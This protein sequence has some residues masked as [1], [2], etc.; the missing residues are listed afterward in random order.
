M[1]PPRASLVVPAHN[2]AAVIGRLL[3]GVLAGA[4]PGEFS[5]VVVANGCADDT[6]RIAR[7]FGPDVQVIET[8]MPSKAAALRLGDEA[9][10]GFPRLYVDA[11]VELGADDVRALAAVL[12]R[13]G[14]L[15]A[16]PH[17]VLD[18]RRASLLVR[19]YYDVWNRLPAVAGG[20]FG[21]GV[22][23]VTEE[24]NRRLRVLPEVMA[25]DL[26]ASMAFADGERVV[27]SGARVIVHPPRTIADLLR[28]R[29]R[30]ATSVTQV[31]R[32]PDMAEPPRTG[33]RDLA[34][35]ARREPAL[36]HKIAWFALVAV[37]A[38]SRARRAVRRGDFATWLR[39]ESSRQGDHR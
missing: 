17:R 13:P 24:G 31:D 28:R 20:L 36:L 27:T 29:V 34:G 9:A 18:L 39:D 22:I 33:M 10:A 15:A 25:D 2:E 1:S 23:G 8:P 35:L 21:R 14:V 30:A 11:D 12:E 4:A 38:K 16:G 6:A 3:D 26:A 32:R 5:V 7:G 37:I 19:W